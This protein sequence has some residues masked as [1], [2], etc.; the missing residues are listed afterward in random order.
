MYVKTYQP[1]DVF[2]FWRKIQSG[3]PIEYD[4]KYITIEKRGM[5]QFMI[6]IHRTK[7][8]RPRGNKVEEFY[9]HFIHNKG[10]RFDS[11]FVLLNNEKQIE[12]RLHQNEVT[13]DIF[14]TID[15]M[16]STIPVTHD[17]NLI[18]EKIKHLEDHEDY[19]TWVKKLKVQRLKMLFDE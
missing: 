14:E 1:C 8:Y 16:Y 2:A 19:E 4:F 18:I 10:S 12:S 6:Y 3:T 13:G 7:F 17:S 15:C 5:L 9:E 11:F